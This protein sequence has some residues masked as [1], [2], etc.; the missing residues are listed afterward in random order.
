MSPS[1]T[2][3]STISLV[4]HVLIKR[5]DRRAAVAF[6]G[7]GTRVCPKNVLRAEL[8]G[9]F[10]AESA[11]PDAGKRCPARLVA[12]TAE[13]RL[14]VAEAARALLRRR[15][16]NAEKAGALLASCPKISGLPVWSS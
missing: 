15:P 11:G 13:N 16:K 9:G 6:T 4:G 3:A 2:R 5:A 12:T 7:S 10:P 8:D 14:N 1:R